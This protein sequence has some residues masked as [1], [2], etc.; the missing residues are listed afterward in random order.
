MQELCLSS[1]DEVTVSKSASSQQKAEAQPAAAS[2]ESQRPTRPSEHPLPYGWVRKQSKSKKGAVYYANILTGKT[3]VERPGGTAQ[4][5]PGASRSDG[6]RSQMQRQGKK[7]TE[8]QKQR[9]LEEEEKRRNQAVQEAKIAE[10]ELEEVKR[11]AAERRAAQKALEENPA[12]AQDKDE[13]EEESSDSSKSDENKEDIERWKQEE[14]QREDREA[15]RARTDEHAA[16]IAVPKVQFRCLDVIKDGAF[17]ERHALSG[18][19]QRWTVGRSQDQV[20]FLCA[21]S[22]VSRVHA[23]LVAGGGAGIF[24]KDLASGHGVFVDGSRIEKNVH[25]QLKHGMALRFG[26]S[27]RTYVYHEPSQ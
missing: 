12:E 2:T 27:S 13:N 7:E 4:K 10:A 6:A 1:D 23:E 26:A 14:K 11:K 21:H 8:E 24:V 16:E 3:Q 15:K 19:K 9:R 22:S 20:D 25:V 5:K 17:V 18:D